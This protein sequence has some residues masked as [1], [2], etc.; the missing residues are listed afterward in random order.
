VWRAYP[1]RGCSSCQR[2]ASVWEGVLCARCG[3]RASLVVWGPPICLSGRRCS[4]RWHHCCFIPPS[5]VSRCPIAA[6]LVGWAH[7]PPRSDVALRACVLAFEYLSLW[8]CRKV[9]LGSGGWQQPPFHAGRLTCHAACVF[10]SVVQSGAALYTGH[11]CTLHFIACVRGSQRQKS[12]P[13]VGTCLVA[14]GGR[15]GTRDNT[16]TLIVVTNLEAH[17]A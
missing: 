9:P 17:A 5:C 3:C 12:K 13:W 2:R 15:L 14:S 6:G 11:A 16:C 1:S 4:K 7:H 10:I 8:L